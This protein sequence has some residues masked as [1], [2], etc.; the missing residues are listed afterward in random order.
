MQIQYL[1]HQDIKQT[2]VQF[3][4]YFGEECCYQLKDLDAEIAHLQK[5]RHAMTALHSNHAHINTSNNTIIEAV[6]T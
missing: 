6:T 5:V 2:H 4:G 3:N 1:H